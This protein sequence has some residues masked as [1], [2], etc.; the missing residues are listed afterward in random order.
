MIIM[1]K[2]IKYVWKIFLFNLR[3][4]LQKF[5]FGCISMGYHETFKKTIKLNSNPVIVMISIVVTLLLS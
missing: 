3:I 1:M 2:N 4:Q 5:L